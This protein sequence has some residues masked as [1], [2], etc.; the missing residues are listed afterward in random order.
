MQRN[1]IICQGIINGFNMYKNAIEFIAI[2]QKYFTLAYSV[3]LP[4]AVLSLAVNLYNFSRLTKSKEY[5]EMFVSFLFISGHFWYMLFFN[6]LGQKVI[7]HSSNVF[8]RIYNVQWYIA[9]LK[10]QKLL[11]LIMQRSMRHCTFVIDSLFIMSFEGFATVK[12]D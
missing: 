12:F 2:I 6:Y 7:D 8:H 1:L 9:P 10:A 3:L 4:L 11:L 5:Y